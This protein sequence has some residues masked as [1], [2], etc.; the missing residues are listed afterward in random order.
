ML[1]F[2]LKKKK[3]KKFFNFNLQLFLFILKRPINHYHL[4]HLHF[5]LLINLGP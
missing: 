3:K 1:I 2:F 4:Q 5:L